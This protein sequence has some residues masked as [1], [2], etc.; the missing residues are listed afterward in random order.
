MIHLSKGCFVVILIEKSMAG[1][2]LPYPENMLP[3][4]RYRFCPMC[5]APLG[6]GAASEDG[7]SRPRCPACGWVHYP[8]SA[9]GVVVVVRSGYGIVAIFPPGLPP[10][11]P[12][13]LPAGH[14]EYGEAPEEAA[15]RKV[16]EETGLEVEIMRCFGS[17]F[18]RQAEYPG[19]NLTFLFE[20]RA[21]GGRLNESAEGTA[22]VFPRELFPAISPLRRGSWRAW[23]A[24]LARCEEG[25]G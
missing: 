19:S 9:I 8:A 12:A 20:A 23:Q 15:R 16:R 3:R 17:F 21:I 6:M 2:T 22:A 7:I 25:E 18:S 13:A 11:T 5:A 10:E 1:S 24:Y 4:L 14:C